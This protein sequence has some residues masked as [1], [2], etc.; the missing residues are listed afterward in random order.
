MV[1]VGR[2]LKHVGFPAYAEIGHWD[3]NTDLQLPKYPR[4]ESRSRDLPY[5]IAF[6]KEA[7]GT[8]VP[9]QQCVHAEF[10]TNHVVDRESW[11][12]GPHSLVNAWAITPISEYL[13]AFIKMKPYA[14]ARGYVR[15]PLKK[16]VSLIM[17]PSNLFGLYKRQVR[18]GFPA[19]QELRES[20]KHPRNAGALSIVTLPWIAAFHH[21]STSQHQLRLSH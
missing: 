4:S 7:D 16:F 6:V 12:R 11:Q 3:A 9:L 19:L 8:I 17:T 13:D 21:A 5:R 18:P 20:L 10:E 1:K 14:Y 15:G 2:A